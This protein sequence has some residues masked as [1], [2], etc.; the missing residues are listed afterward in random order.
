MELGELFLIMHEADRGFTEK[1]ILW[2]DETALT[3][4]RV[5]TIIVVVP[6]R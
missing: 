6:H 3:L 2:T 1:K 4:W 5:T